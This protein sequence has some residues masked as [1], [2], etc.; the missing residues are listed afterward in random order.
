MSFQCIQ[1]VLLIYLH[2]SLTVILS[3]PALLYII[4]WHT[5]WQ[6]QTPICSHILR[7][8][9]YG[10]E[11]PI[12]KKLHQIKEQPSEW[13]NTLDLLYLRG[14]PHQHRTDASTPGLLAKE[15]QYCMW[16]GFPVQHICSFLISFQIIFPF[17]P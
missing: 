13:K 11:I 16:K 4:S 3:E 15:R 2:L 10:K 12:D 5:G 6:Q 17:A 8:S 7:M 9:A 14:R 1:Q